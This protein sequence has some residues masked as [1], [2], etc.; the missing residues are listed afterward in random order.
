MPSMFNVADAVEAIGRGTAY[1]I[2]LRR[3]TEGVTW[4]VWGLATGVAFLA[5]STTDPTRFVSW[6]PIIVL[7]PALGILGTSAAWRIAA[8]SRATLA[9]QASRS[10]ATAI[11][12]MVALFAALVTA[13]AI[14][15]GNGPQ[16]LFLASVLTALPWAA[17]AMLQWRRMTP[18]GQRAMVWTGVA[19]VMTMLLLMQFVLVPDRE[20]SPQNLLIAVAVMG[21]PPFAL[22]VWRVFRG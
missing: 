19:M 6:V 16:P 20:H 3:R 22:G 21:G 18:G 11:V 8:L 1:D 17:F 2:P 15:G 5:F 4:M 9:P 13:L 10:S 7:W 14:T 12:V